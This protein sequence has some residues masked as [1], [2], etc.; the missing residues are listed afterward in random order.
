[1]GCEAEVYGGG[2]GGYSRGV[3]PFRVC[4]GGGR[5]GGGRGDTGGR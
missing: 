4:N 3:S 5:G 2:G 1:M